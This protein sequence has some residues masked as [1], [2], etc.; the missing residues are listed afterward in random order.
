MYDTVNIAPMML[1]VAAERIFQ[2]FDY[3]RE[4]RV[5]WLNR[6]HPNDIELTYEGDSIARWDGNTL[7]VDTIGYNDKTM[8]TQNIGHKKAMF[9]I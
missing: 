7:V 8:I 3:H 1:I 2:L 4:W 5:W 6:E 9:F